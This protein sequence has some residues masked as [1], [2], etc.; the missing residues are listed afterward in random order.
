LEKLIR[1]L[2]EASS[3]ER[4]HELFEPLFT[5]FAQLFAQLLAQL[6][7]ELFV[8]LNTHEEPK[9]HAAASREACR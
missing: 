4:V 7:V 8:L 9:T 3:A 6:S 1:G 5:Q 2:N